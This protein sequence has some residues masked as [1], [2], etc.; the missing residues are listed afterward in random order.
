MLLCKFCNSDKYQ[1]ILSLRNHERCCKGN[2]NRIPVGRPFKSGE[3]A[4][5]KGLT[6]ETDERVMNQSVSLKSNGNAKGV[7]STPEK[8]ELR[9]SKIKEK[10]KNNG[11]MREGSGL[12]KSGWYNG[13]YCRSSWELA[14]V[15]YHLEHNNKILPC[16][17]TRYYTWNGKQH[18]YYPDFVLDGNIIE[19]KGYITEKWKQKHLEN[20][21]IILLTYKELT[22]VLSYVT[23]KYGK[24]FII[25][26]QES[27]A[28]SA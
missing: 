15:I 18:R 5:N 13:F 24:D 3:E 16:K 26:Y 2:T 21:D 20:P 28:E 10:S 4:W 11:G 25:L 19:I 14:F 23:D 8:E 17:E 9:R 22:E 27:L 6:K 7:A 1:K 12:G